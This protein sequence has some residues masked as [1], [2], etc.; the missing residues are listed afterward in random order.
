MVRLSNWIVKSIQNAEIESNR[1]RDIEIWTYNTIMQSPE[2]CNDSCRNSRCCFTGSLAYDD[3]FEAATLYGLLGGWSLVATDRLTDQWTES[4]LHSHQ[5]SVGRAQKL[6]DKITG[7]RMS[8]T[9]AQLCRRQRRHISL[10]SLLK[11]NR[12]LYIRRISV[13]KYLFKQGNYYPYPWELRISAKYLY[14]DT[15][16]RIS[17][18]HMSQV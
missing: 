4:C 17:G 3:S 5:L 14:A 11:I 18:T 6:A 9:P 1:H 12:W 10:S 16:P 7:R 15:Y 2:Q 13:A 8:P